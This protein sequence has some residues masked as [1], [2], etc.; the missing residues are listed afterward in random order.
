[1]RIGKAQALASYSQ[2]GNLYDKAQAEAGWITLKTELLPRGG[3]VTN[4]EE[5]SP[6]TST[7]IS[8]SI[9]AIPP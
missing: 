6:T 7:P 5:A 9:G 8:T 1:M 2:P 3:A 4:L